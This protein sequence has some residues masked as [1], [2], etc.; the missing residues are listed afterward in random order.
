MF[1]LM[2]IEAAS[3]LEALWEKA[4]EL[5]RPYL[6]PQQRRVASGAQWARKLGNGMSHL[7]RAAWRKTLTAQMTCTPDSCGRG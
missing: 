2:Q 4:G 5:G 7:G 3:W 1:E 6:Y